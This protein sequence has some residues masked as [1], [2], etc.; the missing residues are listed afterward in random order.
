MNDN[1]V[2][3]LNPSP[4]DMMRHIKRIA[5]DTANVYISSHARMRMKKR[6]IIQKHIYLCLQKGFVTEGPYRDKKGDWRC[7]MTKVSAGIEL[8]VVVTVKFED[9]LL[10]VTTF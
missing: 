5:E 10:V 9:K 2:L 1:V 7:N 4:H 6:N 8:T 3:P